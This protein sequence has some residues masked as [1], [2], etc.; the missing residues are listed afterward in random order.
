MLLGEN[1]DYIENLFGNAV[2]YQVPRYQRRYVWDRGEL[3][4]ALGGYPQS[5]GFGTS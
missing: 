3:A 2:Q 5:D 4:H 1:S